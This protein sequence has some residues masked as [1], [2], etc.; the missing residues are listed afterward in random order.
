MLAKL[1]HA[2]PST[3]LNPSGACSTIRQVACWQHGLLAK[4]VSARCEY[5]LFHGN[6]GSSQLF[7]FFSLL[8]TLRL[9]GIT[10]MLAHY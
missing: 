1:S 2:S 10:V 4:R 9:L 8:S 3:L 5:K 6:S 7:D